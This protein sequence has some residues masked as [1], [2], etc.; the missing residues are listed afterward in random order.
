MM[1]QKISF[2]VFTLAGFGYASGVSLLLFQPIPGLLNLE[3]YVSPSGSDYND[4]TLDKPWKTV[5]HALGKLSPGDVLYLRKGI[6]YEHEIRTSVSGNPSAPITIRSY[7]GERARIDGGLSYFKDA[8]NTEWELVDGSIHLYRSKRTF[9]GQFMSAWLVHANVQLIQYENAENL[10]STSYNRLN[11]MAPCYIGPGLRLGADGHVYIR[12][13]YN[14]NDLSPQGWTGHHLDSVPIDVNPN[15]HEI[16]LFN[17]E[18]I[19]LLDGASYLHFKDLDFSH[20]IRMID[21]RNGSHHI[22]LNGCTFNYGR[23]GLVIRDSIHDWNIH[24]CEFNNGFPD[25][26]YWT[27]VKNW[28]REVAEAYPEFQSVAVT[29]PMINFHIQHNAFRNGFDALTVHDKTEN[30][31]IINNV[32]KYMRD[33][34]INLYKGSKNVNIAYNLLWRVGSGF[35][36]LS[37]DEEPGHVYIHHNIIDNSAWQRGG[38]PGNYREDRWPVR[39]IINPFT[40]HDDG[41]KASWWKLYNN[42]IITRKGGHKLSPAGP[43]PVTGN[44]EKYVYNNIFYVIDDRI[45]Y[46][47]ELASSG[48]HYD[49]NLIF[50]KA[51]GN[52]PL[53]KNFGDGRDYLTLD[54]FRKYSGT[55][56]EVHGLEV[57]PGF[58]VSVIDD[59]DFDAATMWERY[60]PTNSQVSSGIASYSGLNWPGTEGVSYRGAIP[61]REDLDARAPPENMTVK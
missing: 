61:P 57:D 54:E 15:H 34:A 45:I 6:Y 20:S 4:G 28:E 19:L 58:S 42:T 8:A 7:P 38:R 53:F 44:R 13:E 10:E 30:T 18:N 40:I 52:L 31:N 51:P 3:H 59:P 35:S 9:S 5:G 11:G 27:D 23:Y 17:S 47:D 2:L 56:W 49:G 48:A 33:D 29:G 25:Y 26:A 37:S 16:A 41:N 22:E 24:H 36:N 60:R 39:M 50:R 32:I 14:P 55:D 1:N 46:S 12:L 43:K 21:A